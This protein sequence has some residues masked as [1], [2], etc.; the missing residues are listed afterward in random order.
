MK[1]CTK[2]GIEKSEDCF[3]KCNSTKDGLQTSCKECKKLYYSQSRE[4]RLAY[5]RNYRK[6]HPEVHRRGSK[7]YRENNLEKVRESGRKYMQRIRKENP[8]RVHINDRRLSLK[9][10]Y[11]ISIEEYENILQSQNGVCAI[12][13]KPET[14]KRGYFCVDH[15]HKSNKVRGLLCNKC[16][17]ALGLIDDDIE[18]LKSM[19]KYVS[20]S[21]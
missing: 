3:T 15:C 16:N 21:I 18:I 14:N 13:G 7:K 12:C 11:N 9:K 2:C 8:E 4:Y 10:N 20:I 6:E 19:I 5:S 1:K 17:V